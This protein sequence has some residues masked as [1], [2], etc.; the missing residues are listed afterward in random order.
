[1]RGEHER[2]DGVFRYISPEEHIPPDHPLWAIR[3]L[4]IE[5]PQSAVARRTAKVKYW[6]DQGMIGRR[7]ASAWLPTENRFRKISGHLDLW[8]PAPRRQ[9]FSCC[10]V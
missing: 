4:A 1:M 6:H 7:V 3:A 8:E 2:Q 9:F 5:S 10:M